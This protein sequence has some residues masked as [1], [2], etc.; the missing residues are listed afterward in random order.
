[1][2]G[3]FVIF[4]FILLSLLVLF[5]SGA[6]LMRAGYRLNVI[7]P[8]VSILDRG[9]PVRMAG[10]R[11]GEVTQVNFMEDKETGQIKVLVEVFIAK[12]VKI[13]QNYEF[14]VRGT[15]ILSE[16][17]IEI[18]PRPGR[19]P[20]FKD[21]D[22]TIGKE[23]VPVE[24]LIN[25]ADQIAS[26]LEAL[27]GRLRTALEDKEIEASVRE[28][29]VNLASVTRSLSQIMSGSEK[30]AI[31]S[32]Q[33][34]SAATEALES[35]LTRIDRGEGTLGK[36]VKEEELYQEMKDFVREIKTHPW[37]LFRG[38]EKRGVKWIPFI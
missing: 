18:S 13:R 5:V 30:D 33:H 1:M 36:L 27:L 9:A 24:V 29:I 23:P 32:F 14:A 34:L 16:P 15:H 20:F 11:V 17:H 7:F 19:A 35:I 26:H 25:R 4:G 3:T 6:S 38:G 2:V 28:T 22:T 31:E 21:G 8:Y 37:K 10:V 12:R